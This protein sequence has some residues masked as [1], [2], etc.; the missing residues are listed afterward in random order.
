MKTPFQRFMESQIHRIDIDKWCEGERIRND[1]GL[2]YIFRWI[3]YKAEVFK[4][5]WNI[6]KCKSC[7]N[8]ETC[9]FKVLTECD[10][11]IKIK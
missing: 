2:N 8:W 3:E 4:K 7:I 1:P 10:K 9:G 5:R 11:Y 6:S